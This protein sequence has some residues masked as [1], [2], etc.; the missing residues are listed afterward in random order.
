MHHS[1]IFKII[2]PSKYS[3]HFLLREP[4]ESVRAAHGGHGYTPLCPRADRLVVFSSFFADLNE[5]A[6]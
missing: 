6:C 3:A 2:N 1:A 4:R 5:S